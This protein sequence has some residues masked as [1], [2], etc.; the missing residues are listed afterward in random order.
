MIAPAAVDALTRIERH[1]GVDI[2]T[3][4]RALGDQ[5]YAS[6][7]QHRRQ[8]LLH[9]AR[10]SARSAV[11]DD[12]TI[13]KTT[14]IAS[15]EAS[16]AKK[17]FILDELFT[18][19]RE[20]SSDSLVLASE[21]RRLSSLLEKKSIENHILLAELHD[22]RTLWASAFSTTYS[23]P[24]HSAH[25]LHNPSFVPHSGAQHI[26]PTAQSACVSLEPL[27]QLE[28]HTD[29]L[30]LKPDSHQHTEQ[31]HTA[32]IA[33]NTTAAAARAPRIDISEVERVLKPDVVCCSS[34]FE[35]GDAS[36][37]S[38]TLF[39]PPVMQSLTTES[40]QLAAYNPS[41]Q[42]TVAG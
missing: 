5:K 34:S 29:T 24:P 32:P 18:Q 3:Y 39:D 16:R 14:N 4:V 13:R 40:S 12:V 26:Q 23:P 9:R 25:A 17:Q 27:Q 20:N 11:L 19:L 15:A 6:I 7:K 33:V 30:I 31:M 35:D 22:Q 37:D 41:N 2:Q 21:L 38:K 1:R 10:K 28:A 42:F 8:A 36:D